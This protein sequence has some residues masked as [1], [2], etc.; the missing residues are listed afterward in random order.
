MVQKMKRTQIYLETDLDE[1]LGRLAAR[2]GV[3]KAHLLREGAWRIIHEELLEGEDPILAI[4]GLGNGGPGKT[5]EEHD[6][7]LVQRKLIRGSL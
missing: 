4:V 6:Q 7:Y 3:S 2:R 5:S 1:R